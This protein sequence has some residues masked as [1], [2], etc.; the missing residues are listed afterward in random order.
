MFEIACS[1]V[2]LFRSL[3]REEML[4]E[5]S[6]GVLSAAR[7]LVRMISGVREARNSG[8]TIYEMRAQ[9]GGG[10]ENSQSGREVCHSGWRRV[11]GGITRHYEHFQSLR[12]SSFAVRGTGRCSLAGGVTPG[13][14]RLVRTVSESAK[15]LESIGHGSFTGSES[16]MHDRTVSLEG[17]R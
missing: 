5:I 12:L 17:Q 2:F 16:V 13:Q 4:E 1:F 11:I 14:H 15:P 3:G 8:P 9:V 10:A 6:R 7:D